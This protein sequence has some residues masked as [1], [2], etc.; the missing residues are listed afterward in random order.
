[1]KSMKLSLGMMSL[2]LAALACVSAPFGATP[3]PTA[4][5]A[6]IVVTATPGPVVESAPLVVL[7]PAA[8][9]Q[10]YIDLY[11]RVNPAVV[12]IRV[13]DSAGG[14][15]LGSGFVI[16]AEG[17]VVTNN[18][19]VEG[20]TE[21]EVDFSSGLKVRG[22]LLGTDATSDLAVIKVDVPADQL[23]I[24]LLGDSD[25][26]QVGER[27]IAIGNPFGLNG[28]MT[29]GIVSGLGRVLES[30]VTAPGGGSFSAP[31]IIQTDAAI[32]PGNSGGPLL[33]LSGEV[34]GVNK[35]IESQTGVN[36]GVG[37]SIASNTIKRIAPALISDGKFTYPYLGIGSRDD[38][39]LAEIEAL[40]LSQTTGAYVTQVTAGGPADAAGLRAGDRPTSIQ[41]LSAG[42]DLIIAIDGH[43][44][45]TFPDLL[46][47]LVNQTSVG[48]TVTLTILRDG[49]R[50]DVAVTLG[51]RP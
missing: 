38:L 11:N 36:S 49:E 20:A 46:S 13:A 39:T 47:Y 16:D 41:G 23:T 35:A 26:V 37:F 28:T 25:Q 51:A 8:E 17:H 43:E 42:G 31:D 33:N 44:V 3:P 40:S 29:I 9:Q 50:Q 5:P 15:S 22:E 21:I 24:V 34:I 10:L 32:N 1:M 4:T 48:Q 6:V 14:E 27:V 12:A 19:V 7:D 18:H 45:R 30:S 2:L